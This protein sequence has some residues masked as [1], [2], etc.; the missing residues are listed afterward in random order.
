MRNVQ[1]RYRVNMKVDTTCT[2]NYTNTFELVGLARWVYDT[3]VNEGVSYRNL[4]YLRE[5]IVRVGSRYMYI[6]LHCT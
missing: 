2:A 6:I 5:Y 1:L 3:K 4:V